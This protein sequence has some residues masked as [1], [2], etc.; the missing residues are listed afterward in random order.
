MV[1]SLVK[2]TVGP[3]HVQKASASDNERCFGRMVR[4]RGTDSKWTPTVVSAIR[5]ALV[6]YGCLSKVPNMA[7]L[8]NRNIPSQF[9]RPEVRDRGTS[10]AVL[11][12]KSL[13][14]THWKH[15]LAALSEKCCFHGTFL[16]RLLLGS[17]R[18]PPPPPAG[19]CPTPS[20]RALQ[21]FKAGII[22]WLPDCAPWSL[23]SGL[24]LRAPS[25]TCFH[26]P[27][28]GGQDA[29]THPSRMTTF[30]RKTLQSICLKNLWASL[31]DS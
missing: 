31:A 7:A 2:D 15:A 27:E 13:G 19:K 23:R 25:H 14:E 4:A 16:F 8:N 6:S 1:S 3:A 9:W 11:S 12:L 30:L 5:S 10:G 18:K 21:W 22:R 17:S 29:C 28:R 20:P 24:E 26:I